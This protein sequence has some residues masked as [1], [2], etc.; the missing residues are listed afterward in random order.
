MDFPYPHYMNFP[1]LYFFLD[2]SMSQSAPFLISSCLSLPIRHALFFPH[3]P[4]LCNSLFSC[5]FFFFLNSLSSSL[6]VC[7]SLSRYLTTSLFLCEASL[8]LNL[9][10]LYLSIYPS[11]SIL[12]Y[13][14]FSLSY[15][16][17]IY[18]LVSLN[19]SVSLSP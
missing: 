7:L 8:S 4:S 18:L 12:F 13:L 6:P 9:Y 11:I 2:L 1:S 19:L 14:S 10:R 3:S 5:S 15:F 17:S 16:L